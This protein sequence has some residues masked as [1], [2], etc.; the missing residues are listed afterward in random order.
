MIKRVLISLAILSAFPWEGKAHACEHL[1]WIPH[2]KAGFTR[3]LQD[4]YPA[5][6][7]EALTVALQ[8]EQELYQIPEC[9]HYASQIASETRELLLV[10]SRSFFE[11]PIT[12]PKLASY[13]A[14]LESVRALS[15]LYR[16]LT[17]LLPESDYWVALEHI[18]T[19]LENE[20]IEFEFSSH[21]QNT[22]WTF[23]P[24]NS[25]WALALGRHS[26]AASFTQAGRVALD[27]L[28]VNLST[29]E[30]LIVH[31]WAHFAHS[32]PEE[33]C[34]AQ[35]DEETQAWEETL[36]F[37]ELHFH[38]HHLSEPPWIHGIRI[39][40]N[41]TSPHAWAR[42]IFASRRDHRCH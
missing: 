35:V 23:E 27:P 4:H 24:L 3:E 21:Y 34:S 40:M 30:L 9:A 42:S 16:P 10:F 15:R 31:E 29:L 36:R 39:Q 17:P 37:S 12:R 19:L 18:R 28:L 11:S 5:L 20:L 14:L 1:D 25:E 8:L 33:S 6:P 22:Q 7:I 41:L 38:K 26:L 2:W 32:N 13:F